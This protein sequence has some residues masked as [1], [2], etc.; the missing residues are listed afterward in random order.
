M[1]SSVNHLHSFNTSQCSRK[2]TW[3]DKSLSS[4]KVLSREQRNSRPFEILSL[5]ESEENSETEQPTTCIG[6]VLINTTHSYYTVGLLLYLDFFC[7]RIS[8]DDNY[9][10]L[11][12][13]K[14]PVNYYFLRALTYSLF[15]RVILR[16]PH[17]GSDQRP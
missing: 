2:Q 5:L 1:Y 8:Y 14:S 16:I 15:T 10:S 9:R 12:L 7:N 13:P 4:P 3:L 17:L 11:V 6:I